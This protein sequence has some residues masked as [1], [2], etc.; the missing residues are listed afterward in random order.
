MDTA[1]VYAIPPRQETAGLTETYIGNWF[2][3]NPGAREKIIVATKM[4]GPGIQWIR[5]ASGLVPENMETA[6]NGSLKRLQTD[7]IDLYQLHWPQ[8]KTNFFGKM[9]WDENMQGNKEEIEENIFQILT[10]FQKLQKSGKVRHLGLSNENPWG[11]MK[12][13]EIAKKNNLPEIQTV[14]NAYS[15]MQR[16][17]EVGTS[18]ISAYE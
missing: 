15:L 8:R 12:F 16:K 6:L 5:N 10:Q 14:Q 17:Y 3:K 11:V 1:E 9:N 4:V 2:A 13:L 7:Y 18:E